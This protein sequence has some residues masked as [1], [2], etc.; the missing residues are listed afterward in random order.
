MDEQSLVH[1]IFLFHYIIY[2]EIRN[3]DFACYFMMLAFESCLFN[4]AELNMFETLSM[5]QQSSVI[6]K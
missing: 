3:E 5:G 4:T 6:K 2:N 1:T